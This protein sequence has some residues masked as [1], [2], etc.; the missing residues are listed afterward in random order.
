MPRKLTVW[1]CWDDAAT[2]Q[3]MV[4]ATTK[5]EAAERMGTQPRYISGQVASPSAIAQATAE[6]GRVWRRAINGSAGAWEPF[7]K[8]VS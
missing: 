6:P 4:A 3:F 5:K 8:G 2:H 7:E 1:W